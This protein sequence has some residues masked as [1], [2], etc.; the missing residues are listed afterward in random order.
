[1]RASSVRPSPHPYQLPHPYTPHH[2]TTPKLQQSPCI[3]AQMAQTNPGFAAQVVQAYNDQV[4]RLSCY[5]VYYAT[6][7]NT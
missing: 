4:R 1:M 3:L 2:P 5:C 6:L 7:I